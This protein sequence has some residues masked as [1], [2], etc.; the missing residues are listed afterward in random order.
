MT[1]AGSDGFVVLSQCD[2]L[3]RGGGFAEGVGEPF[4]ARRRASSMPTTPLEKQIRATKQQR[5]FAFVQRE[6]KQRAPPRPTIMLPRTRPCADFPISANPWGWC[7]HR[8][9]DLSC[10]P[11]K[12]MRCW[13]KKALKW[14]DRRRR[15]NQADWFL[16]P[17]PHRTLESGAAG[18]GGQALTQPLLTRTPPEEGPPQTST[19]G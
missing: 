17:L 10:L 9:A 1:S 14:P 4:L 18:R 11:A 2:F 7:R 19:I 12:C 8:G 5:P 3:G 13:A 6:R 15:G 16:Q